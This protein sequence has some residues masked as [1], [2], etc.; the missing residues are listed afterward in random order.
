MQAE[1]HK[2]TTPDENNLAKLALT[3]DVAILQAQ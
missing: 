3:R 1:F 2:R